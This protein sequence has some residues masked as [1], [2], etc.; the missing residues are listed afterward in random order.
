MGRQHSKKYLCRMNRSAYIAEAEDA[1]DVYQFHREWRMSVPETPASRKRACRDRKAHQR[2]MDRADDAQVKADRVA[3]GTPSEWYPRARDCLGRVTVAVQPFSPSL[4][5]PAVQAQLNKFPLVSQLSGSRMLPSAFGLSRGK[6]RALRKGQ[7]LLCAYFGCSGWCRNGITCAFLHLKLLQ[8]EKSLQ[9]H[10]EKTPAPQEPL[11]VS[12]RFSIL[13]EHDSDEES[14]DNGSLGGDAQTTLDLDEVTPAVDTKAMIRVF[15]SGL[16]THA[17]ESTLS[18]AI[19]PITAKIRVDTD[20]AFGWC[21]G[22]ASLR[23][24]RVE[25]QNV[26]AMCV[27]RGWSATF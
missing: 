1:M 17:N 18:L 14:T 2:T 12:S 10:I 19:A 24:R 21:T 5:R 6:T 27:E 22:T 25:V 8:P 13:L 3:E 20:A 11:L 16:A 7:G 26:V 23:I 4:T 9:R 15:V